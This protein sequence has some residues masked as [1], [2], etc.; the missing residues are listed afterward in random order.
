M[1][2]GKRRLLDIMEKYV[3]HITSVLGPGPDQKRG[4]PGHQ[5]IELALVR[6]YHLTKVRKW[7][8]LA[9]YFINQRGQQPH[10]AAR[11]KTATRNPRPRTGDGASAIGCGI[12]PNVTR[13]HHRE[14]AVCRAAASAASKRGGFA[15]PAY[16][17]VRFRVK[18]GREQEFVEKQHAVG[19][20]PMK[21]FIEGTLIKTGDRSYCL[22]GHWDRFE[23]NCCRPSCNDQHS[24]Q[25]SGYAGG[26]RWRAWRD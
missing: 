11:A 5:E 13:M 16:N 20:Q 19:S 8:D 17:V 2:T 23:F 15:M 7:L 22:I 3:D 6:L 1:A 24:R 9:A 12:L 25:L 21:G 10:L 14:E 18:P 26:F 4:Y